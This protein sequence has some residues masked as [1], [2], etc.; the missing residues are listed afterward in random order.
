MS[1]FAK[2]HQESVQD[3]GL[4]LEQIDFWLFCDNYVFKPKLKVFSSVQN[5]AWAP[6][7]VPLLRNRTFFK[8]GPKPSDVQLTKICRTNQ[9]FLALAANLEPVGQCFQHVRGILL[10]R[11]HKVYQQ[12]CSLKQIGFLA[13]N[14]Q[15]FWA[16]VLV[17]SQWGGT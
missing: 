13:K 9:T 8:L 7:N 16:T 2:E 5:W 14:S 12:F 3:W 4:L 10:L 17:F 6:E 11:R 1:D 15:I